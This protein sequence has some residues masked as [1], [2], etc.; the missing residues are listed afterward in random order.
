MS[1][2]SIWD[3]WLSQ[4]GCEEV[5]LLEY[6]AKQSAQSRQMISRNISTSFSGS[7]N[8]QTKK[9][10]WGSSMLATPSCRFLTLHILR[11]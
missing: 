9:P 7:H 2:V 10:A 11:S 1:K 8:E 3:L 6:I 5:S 4:R